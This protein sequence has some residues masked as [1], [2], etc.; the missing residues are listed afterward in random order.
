MPFFFLPNPPVCSDEFNELSA[1]CQLHSCSTKHPEPH[2]MPAEIPTIQIYRLF[3]LYTNS[4]TV[5]FFRIENYFG[6]RFVSVLTYPKYNQ[7]SQKYQGSRETQITP[8]VHPHVAVH[9]QFNGSIR[10]QYQ[11]PKPCL[12][13]CTGPKIITKSKCQELLLLPY[14]KCRTKSFSISFAVKRARFEDY[15]FRAE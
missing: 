6:H 5:F 13:C 10:G 1:I 9:K 4:Y 12:L 14:V 8:A 3:M 15:S 2:K 11:P 7:T